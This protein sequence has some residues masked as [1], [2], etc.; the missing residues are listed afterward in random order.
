MDLDNV[1]LD[2]SRLEIVKVNECPDDTK[3]WL[4]KTVDERF[5]AA[6]L[7]RQINYGDKASERLQRVLEVTKRA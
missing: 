6:E 5:S 3:Y 1:K 4:S 7:I 2:K